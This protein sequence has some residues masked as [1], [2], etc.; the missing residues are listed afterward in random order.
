MLE[1][2][3]INEIPEILDAVIPPVTLDTK[4]IPEQALPVLKSKTVKNDDVA[5]HR[6]PSLDIATKSGIKCEACG[7]PMKSFMGMAVDHFCKECIEK[8]PLYPEGTGPIGM[9]NA[10]PK[11]GN[12]NIRNA[13]RGEILNAGMRAINGG[14]NGSDFVLRPVICVE[15]MNVWTPSIDVANI[16]KVKK[17]IYL[18]S[19]VSC[20]LLVLIIFLLSQQGIKVFFNKYWVIFVLFIFC[21]N[22]I[23]VNNECLSKNKRK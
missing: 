13:T 3:P 1:W 5:S 8:P 17:R 7:K 23:F 16:D 11:C 9:S 22:R 6:Q 10:C 20:L 21:L 4:N 14:Y 12:K 19:F 18:Y 2:R 15:C